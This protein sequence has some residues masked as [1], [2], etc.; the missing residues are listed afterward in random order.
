MESNDTQYTVYIRSTK[1]R[2]PVT[3]EE[4]NIYYKEVDVFR[5]KQQRHG[6]CVCPKNNRL[7]CDMDCA[8]CPYR[9]AGD[10]RSLDFTGENDDGDVTSWSDSLA[11]D[12]PLLE[13]LVAAAV[14]MKTVLDRISTLMPE[15][16]EIGK[17]RLEGLSDTEI[18]KQLGIPRTTFLSRLKILK[19]TVLTEYSEIL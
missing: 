11:V 14:D 6:K 17:L 18:A 7:S 3:K 19:A 9:R 10:E 1:E 12:E 16:I 5:R 4:F 8:T 15:A 2:I 13:D